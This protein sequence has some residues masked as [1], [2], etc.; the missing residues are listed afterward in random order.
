MSQRPSAYC[1]KLAGAA[2]LSL[3]MSCRRVGPDTMGTS[4][5]GHPVKFANQP[6]DEASDLIV[7][8][9]AHKRLNSA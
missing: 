1:E 3:A 9:R 8:R 7:A 4:S 2:S 5:H 6:I